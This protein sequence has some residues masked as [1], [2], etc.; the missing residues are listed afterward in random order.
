MLRDLV[1]GIQHVGIPTI[2]IDRT[3]DFYQGLGFDLA[4][5]TTDDSGNLDV[6]FLKLKNLVI[7]TYQEGTELSQTGS[8][9]HIAIDVNDVEEVFKKLMEKNYDILDKEINF[10]PFWQNG[11]KFFTIK[12]PN[13]EQIEFSEML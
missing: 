5:S 13:N 3:V 8:I 2:N 12:G 1:S 4:F 10:L 7:E 9:N 11:V 6:A